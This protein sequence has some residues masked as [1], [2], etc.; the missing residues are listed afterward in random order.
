MA[1]PVIAQRASRSDPGRAATIIPRHQPV[2]APQELWRIKF[3]RRHLL[4]SNP[5]PLFD[6]NGPGRWLTARCG[7]SYVGSRAQCVMA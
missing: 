5:L 2:L 3:V 1:A 6:Y 4:P 7:S